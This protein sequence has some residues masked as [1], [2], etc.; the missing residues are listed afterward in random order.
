MLRR[1]DKSGGK[2]FENL[3]SLPSENRHKSVKSD[4]EIKREIIRQSLAS[5]TGNCPCPYNSDR[6]GRSCGRRSAYSRP[7]GA[8]PVCYEQDV[9]QNMLDAYRRARGYR[10][11]AAGAQ[12]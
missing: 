1:V 2:G 4:A 9:T 10:K 12:K 8:S 5:Y 6:A 11:P 7:G 3:G